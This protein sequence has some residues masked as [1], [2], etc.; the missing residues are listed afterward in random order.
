M[1]RNITRK[2]NIKNII[3]KQQNDSIEKE[4]KKWMKKIFK[5]AC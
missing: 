5:E 4:I 2:E 1:K 3:E